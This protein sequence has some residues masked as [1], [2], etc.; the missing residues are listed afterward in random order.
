MVDDVVRLMKVGP[1]HFVVRD[2][3]VS[4]FEWQR[5]YG[6]FTL[7][8]TECEIVRRAVINQ[9]A[10]HA[11]AA[12]IAEWERRPVPGSDGSAHANE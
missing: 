11:D 3:K 2:L 10:H 9:P 8:E 1:P 6:A 4:D 7:R 12:V 5:G